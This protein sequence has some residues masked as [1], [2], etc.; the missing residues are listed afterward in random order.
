MSLATN[1]AT[2]SDPLAWIDNHTVTLAPPTILDASMCRE[3]WEATQQARDPK[4]KIVIDLRETA[5]I[6]ASGFAL[7]WMLKD[8]LA[9]RRADLFLT[10][11][12]PHLKKAL[13]LRGFEIYFMLS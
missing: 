5:S 2:E 13:Q 4:M 1:F 8:S 3:F 6:H 9:K 7:L 12:Q 10:H 11:C